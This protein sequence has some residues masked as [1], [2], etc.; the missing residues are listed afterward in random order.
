MFLYFLVGV[1][2]VS[3]SDHDRTREKTYLAKVSRV[4]DGDTLWVKPITGGRYRKLRLD[5]ID[6]PEICQAGGVASR[7]AL[8]A[9]V[10]AQHVRVEVRRYDDYG[11]ALVRL[12]VRGDDVS[13]RLISAGH[14]WSYRWRRNL[15][16]YAEEEAVARKDR[17]GLFSE[18]DPELP[19]DFRR[20]HGP[21]PLP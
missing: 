4:F 10:S 20:R 12:S 16:P 6:A 14:A 1:P 11:R 17:K 18:P 21:C 5:G 9:M 15:G 2:A 7:D 19:R 13:A 3:A 8:A